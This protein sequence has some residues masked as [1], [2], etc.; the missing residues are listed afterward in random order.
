MSKNKLHG[1]DRERQR[2]RE[3]E[4]DRQTQTETDRRSKRDRLTVVDADSEWSHS[5]RECW[6]SVRSVGSHRLQTDVENVIVVRVTNPVAVV[7]RLIAFQRFLH[8]E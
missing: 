8:Q 3:T 4:T 7:A 5:S 1:R 6:G 2:Q